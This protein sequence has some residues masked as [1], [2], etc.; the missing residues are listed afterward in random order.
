MARN[1]SLLASGGKPSMRKL[2]ESKRTRAARLAVAGAA[3]TAFLWLLLA[4]FVDAATPAQTQTLEGWRVH[5]DTA[6]C[7]REPALAAKVAREL[8]LRL[9][10][11]QRLLPAKRID[12][13]RRVEFYVHLQPRPGGGGYITGQTAADRDATP[14]G[15]IDLGSAEQFLTSQGEVP[16][17]VLHELAHAY[18][19]QV[20]GREDRDV[21]SAYD[22]ALRENRYTHVANWQGRTV[23]RSYALTSVFEYFALA[24]QSYFEKSGFYPFDRADLEAYDPTVYRL[25]QEVWEKRPGPQ[26]ATLVALG[27]LSRR[28]EEVDGGDGPIEVSTRAIA[29]V[30]AIRNQS[31]TTVEA[32]WLSGHGEERKYADI[33]PQG[34]LLQRVYSPHVWQVRSSEGACLAALHVGPLG[35]HV[36]LEQ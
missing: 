29:A 12:E 34:L 13:L 8:D 28:C 18:H 21:L 10:E 33:P 5:L 17:R 6:L 23:D 31:V 15:S 30:L 2:L 27:R 26:P 25:M 3:R 22:G 36:T 24:T 32:W 20:L 16:S 9:E 1:I 19:F 4:P 11:V 35:L 7:A 14:A